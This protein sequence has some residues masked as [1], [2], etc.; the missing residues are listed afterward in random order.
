MDPASQRV[1]ATATRSL[2][3]G[4]VTFLFTDIEG[5]TQRWESKRDAMKP[6]VARHDALMRGAI[7]AGGGYVFKTIGDAFCAAFR[8]APEAISAALAAQRA[9]ASEDFSSVDGLRVRAALHTGYADERDGD[10]FGP[11]V[12]RVARLLS[13]GHGGQILISGTTADLAQGELPPQTSLR[14]LGAHRLKDLA[15]PEHVFQVVAADLPAEFPPLRSLDAL[16]NNLPLQ[17]TSFVGRETDLDEVKNLVE[18]TRLITLVGPGGVG[19]TRLALQVGADLLDRYPEGVWVIQL[20]ALSDPELVPSEAA[21][22]LNVRVSS[23]RSLTDSIV[24][25]L[26]PKRTLLILDNCEHIVAAAAAFATAVTHGCPNVQVLATSREGLGIE[27]EDIM[28]VA[29]LSVPGKGDILTAEAIAPYGAV[30][31]FSDRAVMANKSFHLSDENSAMV[32]DICRRLDGIPF[33]IELAAARVKALSIADLSHALN[34]RFRVLTGGHRTALPRQKTMR[35]LIDWSFDLLSE[36]E[37]VLLRRVAIFAGWTLE[38]ATQVCQGDG[39][40]ELDVLDLLASLVDKSLVV[41]ETGGNVTRYRLLDSTREYALEKL[42]EQ[43]ELKPLSRAHADFFAELAAKAQSRWGTSPTQEWLEQLEPELDNFRG[44]LEWAL[45]GSNDVNL[46]GLIA[47]HL[48]FFWFYGGLNPEGLRWIDNA[49]AQVG[50]KYPEAEAWLLHARSL[51]VEGKPLLEAAQ[52]SRALFEDLG[53]REG[54]ALALYRTGTG[55]RT[56]GHLNDAEKAFQD[57]AEITR[58]NGDTKGYA[59][60][61]GGIAT[62]CWMR[63]R[64]D[65]AYRLFGEQRRAAAALKDDDIETTC[66]ANLAELEFSRGNVEQA[67]AH[68]L[69]SIGLQRKNYFKVALDYCNL[70]AYRIALGQIEQ[71]WNDARTGL[72]WAREVQNDFQVAL[73]IHHLALIAALKNDARRAAPLLGFADVAFARF[74]YVREPTESICYERLM[75]LLR[76]HLPEDE[77]ATL[78]SEGAAWS[79]NRAIEEALKV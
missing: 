4:T 28:R 20:A 30:A 8:T 60:S 29:S 74:E 26:K 16:P 67:I 64:S 13:I 75:G 5:S 25:A 46:G 34:E 59:M 40:D 10:Y 51:L 68:S 49:L 66:L 19:K 53:N 76:E 73:A 78:R 63:D 31:L 32:A 24:Y 45:N 71:A 79:E 41:A 21:A 54:A 56:L 62:V 23:D 48:G 52:R 18:K 57:A 3:T 9:L 6:A 2:P 58:Q 43:A 33:A 15:H 17:V 42:T 36:T 11:T 1:E 39:I 14:D 12:N 70:T 27:G 35:A 50:G 37:K 72:H 69:R 38:A 77:I 55:L 22:V 7:E 65:E 47:G 44:A 61:I